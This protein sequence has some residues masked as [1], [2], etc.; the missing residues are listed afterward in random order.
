MCLK[1]WQQIFAL[2]LLTM[3]TIFRSP[4][5]LLLLPFASNAALPDLP[6]WNLTLTHSEWVTPNII[7]ILFNLPGRMMDVI[8][9]GTNGR[10]YYMPGKTYS[11][12]DLKNKDQF[13]FVMEDVTDKV[14][15]PLEWSRLL[16]I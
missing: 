1:I 3:K 7:R 14:G 15:T 11:G 12:L 8:V 6:Q 2:L 4:L 10:T 13:T 9:T 16:G 5:W